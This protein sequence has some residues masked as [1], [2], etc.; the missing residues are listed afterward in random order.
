MLVEWNRRCSVKSV[1]KETAPIFDRVGGAL[2]VISGKSG[3]RLKKGFYKH[4]LEG[5]LRY[6]ENI[7]PVDVFER[8]NL[9]AQF[10]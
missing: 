9:F 1:R 2:L 10:Q 4:S 6:F 5:E 3:L 7:A 8:P